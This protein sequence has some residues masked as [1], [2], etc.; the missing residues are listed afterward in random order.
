ML[1]LPPD[2]NKVDMGRI[3]VF[4]SNQIRRT[5][6]QDNSRVNR[7]PVSGNKNDAKDKNK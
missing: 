5:M 2:L 1:G 4:Q 6:E 3:Q 7:F